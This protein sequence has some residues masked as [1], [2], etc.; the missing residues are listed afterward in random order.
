VILVS[1]NSVP[2]S[3]VCGL[4]PAPSPPAIMHRPSAGMAGGAGNEI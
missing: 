4:V 2:S 1:D 3:L